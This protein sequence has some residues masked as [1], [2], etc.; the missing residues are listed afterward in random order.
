MSNNAVVP[1]DHYSQICKFR[2][3][4]STH[5]TSQMHNIFSDAQKKHYR[6][7]NRPRQRSQKFPMSI[8]AYR[9]RPQWLENA[10]ISNY[11]IRRHG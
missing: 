11:I 2:N 6:L 7:S 3:F 4:H 10:A 9:P 8:L 1:I 5:I